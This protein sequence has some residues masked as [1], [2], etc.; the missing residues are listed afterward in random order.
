MIIAHLP[1]RRLVGPA[2]WPAVH[3]AGPPLVDTQGRILANE[4]ALQRALAAW[5]PTL[6]DP[7]VCVLQGECEDLAVPV[8][9]ALMGVRD[10]PALLTCAR[11]V[12]DA[13]TRVAAMGRADRRAPLQPRSLLSLVCARATGRGGRSLST[14]QT[15]AV[16]RLGAAVSVRTTSTGLRTLRVLSDIA[17]HLADDARALIAAYGP[18]PLGL[19]H[20]EAIMRAPRRRHAALLRAALAQRLTVRA[21]RAAVAPRRRRRR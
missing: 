13:L 5:P 7:T 12:D 14:A 11:V 10:G 6:S 2:L 4:R 9:R 18:L 3:L 21:L 15:A 17:R 1:L 20:L 8:L 19:S 16:Y